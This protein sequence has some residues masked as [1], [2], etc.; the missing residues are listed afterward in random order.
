MLN[1]S[2][3]PAQKLLLE[4]ELTERRSHPLVFVMGPLRSGTTLFMQWLAAT[5]VCA[6]PTN[7]LSRFYGAPAIG[8]LIQ[9]LLTDPA[10]NFRDEILDFQSPIAFSSDNG[11]TKGALAPNEFWYFWRRFLPF[12]ELDWLP[13][14]ELE[15][16]VDVQRL[17]D[18]LLGLTRIFGKPFALKGLILNYN[19]PFLAKAFPGALF[20]RMHR[21]PIANVASILDARVRQFG[22]ERTWYS[23]KIPEYPRLKDMDALNQS[24]GQLHFIDS[25]L[26]K[27]MGELD[28]SR[29]LY[30]CYEA[31]CEN[32][33]EI[34]AE[35]CGKLRID[36]EVFKYSGPPK[37]SRSR[38]IDADLA[39]KIEHA[40]ERFANAK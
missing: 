13:D 20:V 36:P 25:A 29:S 33:E 21:D 24:V 7:L 38:S 10:Y 9:Q 4:S 28:E 40:I 27:G 31:F 22:N 12:K 23:F 11:K 2:L 34:Y 14:E 39:S 1:K 18:E 16:I 35:F 26:R 32:P 37:F 6:Y 19:I 8:A 3:A 17:A 5:G 30:V 15:R